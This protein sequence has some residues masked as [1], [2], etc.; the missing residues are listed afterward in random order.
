MALVRR[1][2]LALVGCLLWVVPLRAQE[3]TGA[4]TGKVVDATTQQPLGNVEVAIAGTPHRELSRADGSF[5]LNGIPAGSY[6]LRASRIGYG[7]QIQEITVT[8]GG[9]TTAQVTLAPAAAILEPVVV[10]G[11][12]T[13]R[14]EAITGSVSTVSAAA[15]NVGVITNVDQMIQARAAGVEVTRN[16]G[17][18][19]AGTQILIR[20]GSS[21]SNSNE[22]LYV[23]D[24]V[25]IY[26]VATEPPSFAFTGTPPLPRNPLNLLNPS[27]IASITILKDASATAIYGSRAANGV[28]LVETKKGM[29]AG[30]PSIEYD[31]YVAASSPAKYLNLSTAGEFRTFVTGQVGVWRADSTSRCVAR[32]ALCTDT[33]TFK[34]SL[35]GKLAGLGPTHL[36]ALGT[37]NTDWYRAVTRTAV[38]HNHDLSFS[39]GSEDTRYRASLNY[40]K[41]QGVAISNGLERIQGRLSATHKALDNRM[42]LGVNVTTSRVNDQYILFENRAGFEGGVFQ[43]AA[44][45]NPTQPIK[46]NDTT[47]YEAGGNS[48]RNPVALANQVTN[49]GQTTRTLAN[50]TAE[51]D[52]VPGLTGQVTVGLDYSAGGRQIYFPIANPLGRTLGNGLARVYSQDNATKTV[53][54]LL[55]YRKQVG[56]AHSFD[57]VGGYE[58]SKFT[59]NVAMGQGKGFVT[60]ALLYNSLN[61]AGTLTDSSDA[62]ES[63]LVSFLSRANYGFKDKFFVTGVLRYDG[64]SKFAEGH[65]WAAFPGLSASWHLTQEEFLRGGPFSDLRVRVGWGR[66]GNPGIQPYQSLRTLVGGTGASYPWGDV[67]QAGVIPNSVGNPDLKW[68]QTAQYNGAID[69]GLLNNRLAGSVEYYVKNTSD[70]LLEVPVPQPQPAATRLENVGKLRNKGVEVTLDALIVARPGLTWRSGLTFA[71]E[72]N[73]VLD[74]GPH[75]F[76]RSGIVSGQGQS[77]QWA[78]RIMPGS[79]LGTFFG[80]VFVD[81]NPATGFQRFA[82]SA[83]TAACVNGLTTTRG[84][85][86]AA[87][88]RIIGN[89]NPDF[90]LGFHN[91]LNWHKFDI[92]FLLRASVGQDVFNNTALVWSTK[93]NA[94]QDKNF[95]APAL[96]DSTDLH[97]PAIFSSR[98]VERASFLRLQNLTVEYALDL[99][100][101][102]RSA[103][104]ARLYVSADN[105]FVLTGYSGLDPEVS[106][107]NPSDATDVGLAA[108]GIDYLSYPRPRTFT[109]GLRVAF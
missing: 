49:L 25:P 63:R 4:V 74:L 99:P 52:L 19:G 15:A 30:G 17:E 80:P 8:P 56:E 27:D 39:G 85:P 71:A 33:T 32:P 54:T 82:C 5:T 12:G 10:T 78:E 42:R 13:Q 97:E 31:S 11:Y 92:T 77:D 59:K 69:F 48:L 14:R 102:T 103:R 26:N 100:F 101:L 40:M 76:I 90:T 34:D 9:T 95:L 18:P 72:R 87:D 108:R 41:Q 67:P 47:Y 55:T 43:N 21:I 66:Q 20:G 29:A 81:V 70:L 84:V 22:P 86:N 109:G 106:S 98:W 51:L 73:K 44:V 104:S 7:S 28:I 64:S 53:Q 68:E 58:Y 37:A 46:L 57:V 23:I 62:T 88:Y 79:P 2:A 6:R 107:L 35:V 83:A 93:S 65:K 96:T 61:A 91:Q 105:L 50:G 3:S 36:G 24:G 75:K 1:L 45:F 89:A 60:D 38:T 94:L 16:N